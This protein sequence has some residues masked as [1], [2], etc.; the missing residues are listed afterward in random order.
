MFVEVL[1]LD[2]SDLERFFDF[3]WS[4]CSYGLLLILV[5]S[6]YRWYS[7]SLVAYIFSFFYDYIPTC[8]RVFTL[9]YWS[10]CNL[11]RFD[12]HKYK[13]KVSTHNYFFPNYI[14]LLRIVDITVCRCT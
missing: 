5:P 13:R 11:L 4:L 10:R 2:R 8:L 6:V 7:S 12:T 9:H 14:S 3:E 1:F